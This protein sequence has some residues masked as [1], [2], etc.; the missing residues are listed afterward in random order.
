M[1][2]Y[3]IITFYLFIFVRSRIIS[4][5]K[6]A[7]KQTGA[8]YSK[9]YIHGLHWWTGLYMERYQK[10]SLIVL[11]GIPLFFLIISI[12][13]ETWG[14]V[15]WSLPPSFIAGITGYFHSKKNGGK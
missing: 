13:T 2:F 15:L 9:I 8:L 14:F 1:C 3:E 12:L 10:I 4:R 11:I 5:S 7:I 6:S